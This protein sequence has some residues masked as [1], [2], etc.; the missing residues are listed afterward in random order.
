MQFDMLKLW[1]V[2]IIECVHFPIPSI[3]CNFSRTKYGRKFMIRHHKVLDPQVG[4]N[5]VRGD[6]VLLI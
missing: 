2:L 6:C 5:R 1:V 3:I 4:W